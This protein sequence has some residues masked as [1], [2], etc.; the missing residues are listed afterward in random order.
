[1]E[2]T[3][4][5]QHH[6]VP[7]FHIAYGTETVG[8]RQPGQSGLDQCTQT[9]AFLRRQTHPRRMPVHVFALYRISAGRTNSRRPVA[10]HRHHRRVHPA[11]ERRH[12]GP[13]AHRG[14]RNLGVSSTPKES[15]NR[16]GHPVPGL[17]TR[18]AIGRQPGDSAIWQSGVPGYRVPSGCARLPSCQVISAFLLLWVEGAER[19][20]VKLFQLLR[21]HGLVEFAAPGGAGSGRAARMTCGGSARPYGIGSLTRQ[22]PEALS[23]PRRRHKLLDA[24]SYKK[25][26]DSTGLI[27]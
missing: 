5:T 1:V 4:S 16:Q 8:A 10:Q 12:R 21:H 24:C 13:V 14:P 11:G 2:S 26:V 19:Y 7:F 3:S 25:S 27:R 17:G 15:A 22:A 20:A 9:G 23:G 18:N 6:L